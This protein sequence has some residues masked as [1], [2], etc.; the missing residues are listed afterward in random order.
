MAQSREKSY[1]NVRRRDLEFEVN[2][3]VDFK[4][5]PMKAL[6]RFGKKRKVNRRYVA[7]HKTF[8]C[9]GKVSYELYF[10]NYLDRVH[11]V[12]I[13]SMLKRLIGDLTSI[14]IL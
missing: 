7:S 4:M 8:N 6:I 11:T 12:F 10:P 5:S 1:A 3:L 13:F 2:I 9:I 14:I